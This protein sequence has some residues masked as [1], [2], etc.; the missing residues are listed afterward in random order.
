MEPAPQL[1]I[2]SA[3]ARTGRILG[4]TGALAWAFFLPLS[5]AHQ[6]IKAT[7]I[8]L[9]V[10]LAGFLAC[11][12]AFRFDSGRIRPGD[13]RLLLPFAALALLPLLHLPLSAESARQVVLRAPFF[14][15]PFLL[16][17]GWRTWP[18]RSNRLLAGMLSAGLLAV[19]IMLLA[20]GPAELYQRVRN[21]SDEACWWVIS[22]PYLGIWLGFMVF[23]AAGTAA[24]WGRKIQVQAGAACG[25][26]ALGLAGAL[27]AKMAFL[28]LAICLPGWLLTLYRKNL[29]LMMVAVLL[30]AAGAGTGLYRFGQTR[31]WEDLRDKGEIRFETLSKT[32]ANSINNRLLLWRAAGDLLT[33]PESWKGYAPG[34]VQPELDRAVSRYNGYLETVHLNVHNQLLFMAL[35]HGWPGLLV[36]LWV[37]VALF[38]ESMRAGVPW[39]WGTFFLFICSQTEVYWD[40]ETGVQLWIAWVFFLAAAR[41]EIQQREDQTPWQAGGGGV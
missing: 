18:G 36:W 9:F 16:V 41:D 15:F 22:R 19:L 21:L 12:P 29:R 40:R 13:F 24:V 38:R 20:Q 30:L 25:L 6:H 11:I 37:W 5:Q 14:A 26:A 3:L 1:T 28:A 32:Y 31:V 17:H 34:E 4:F 23:L 35:H 2:P 8:C 39:F 27:L 7:S 33:R 10:V